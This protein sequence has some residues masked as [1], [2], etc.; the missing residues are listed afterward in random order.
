MAEFRVRVYEP[1]TNL[2]E[3]RYET[4]V[5][6]TN[7]L[8]L[9]DGV[10]LTPEHLGG[11]RSAIVRKVERPAPPDLPIAHAEPHTGGGWASN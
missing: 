3:L 9:E 7:A 6:W 5:T 4:N 11:G 10:N 1:G 8:P 2:T